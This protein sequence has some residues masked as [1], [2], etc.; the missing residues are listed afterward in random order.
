VPKS[1]GTPDL[2]P[3]ED[4]IVLDKEFV[5]AVTHSQVSDALE[6]PLAVLQVPQNSWKSLQ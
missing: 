2:K 6:M 5:V 3:S 4:A 1:D